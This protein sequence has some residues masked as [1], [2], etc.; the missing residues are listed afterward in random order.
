MNIRSINSLNAM[1]TSADFA[2]QKAIGNTG[3]IFVGGKGVV[4]VANSTDGFQCAG[5]EATMNLVNKG[6]AA[7]IQAGTGAVGEIKKTDENGK[8]YSVKNDIVSV[9][10]GCYIA[11]SKD[12][13][14]LLSIGQNCDIDLGDGANKA[15]ISGE[16]TKV[17]S[18][19]GN[20]VITGTPAGLDY[21]TLMSLDIVSMLAKIYQ[22]SASIYFKNISSTEA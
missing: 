18:G 4:S 11:G 3:G 17:N 22:N 7:H 12:A 20:D 13:D 21:A 19:A 10:H 8:E 5:G 6:N 9:G 2:Q 1:K 14:V 15:F 16:G